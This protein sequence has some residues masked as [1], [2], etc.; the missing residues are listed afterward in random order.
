MYGFTCVGYMH[1]KDGRIV[2][3]EELTPEEKERCRNSMAERSSR[4]M[5]EYYANHP[6][7]YAKLP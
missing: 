1:M 2:P 5:S 7:E 6:D 4:V 3:V